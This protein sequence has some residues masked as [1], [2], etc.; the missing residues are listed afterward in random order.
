[1]LATAP[2]RLRVGVGRRTRIVATIGPAS[3]S[4][5]QLAAL[6]DAGMDVARLG[7]AHGSPEDHLACVRRVR[8]AA[9]RA[10]RVVGVLADLP[11]PKVR[12]GAFVRPV[13]LVEGGA[14][15]L[16]AGDLPSHERTVAVDYP[17]LLADIEAGD[18]VALGDGAVV[19]RVE[20]IRADS[21]MTVVVNGGALQGRPGVHL[22]SGRLGVSAPTAADLVLLEGC[23]AAGVDMVAISFVRRGSDVARLRAAAQAVVGEDADLP[24]LVAK[25]ETPVAIEHLD[26]IVEEAD[27]VMVARGDLGTECPL[28]DVPHLQKRI[29]RACMLRARPVITATQML[30]SMT[31]SATPT[32]AEA[33]DVANAVLDGTDAVML[34]GETAVGHDPAGAVRTMARIAERAE[35]EADELHWAHLLDEQAGSGITEAITHAAWRAARDTGATA[36]LCCTWSGNTVRAL[37]RFRPTAHLV[38]LSPNPC[39]VRRLALCWGAEAMALGEH[40]S[41]EAMVDAAVD[42]ARDAGYVVPGDVAVVLAGGPHQRDSVTDV[43]RL[44]HVH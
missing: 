10:G 24:L 28:E 35:R 11:G 38:G 19:L 40:T 32:R 8:H 6:V 34:S 25:I 23:L 5:E 29:V 37:S 20:E 16:V 18:R 17:D 14:L 1:M 26:E 41:A 30:E 4:P 7:F 3:S 33:S 39:T 36:I 9:E 44:V 21:A 42:A 15:R 43:L 22:P 13:T 2:L 27:A 12:A 31:H